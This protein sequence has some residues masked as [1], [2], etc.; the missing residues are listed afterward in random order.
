VEKIIMPQ[1]PLLLPAQK[2]LLIYLVEIAERAP[3]DRREHF[4][5]YYDDSQGKETL[6]FRHPGLGPSSATAPF[7]DFEILAHNGLLLLQPRRGH[8]DMLLLPEA[9]QYYGHIKDPTSPTVRAA[10]REATQGTLERAQRALR[11]YERT[12]AGYGSLSLP[13]HIALEMEDKRVEVEDLEQRVAELDA[14]RLPPTSTTSSPPWPSTW[15]THAA[16]RWPVPSAQCR[17]W[18]TRSGPSIRSWGRRWATDAGLAQ[19]ILRRPRRPPVA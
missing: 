12:A 17:S 3:K 10:V 14:L 16:S 11:V 15:P 6:S 8:I 13:P 4:R 2:E 7:S 18:C 9:Y 1:L 19:W 5:I